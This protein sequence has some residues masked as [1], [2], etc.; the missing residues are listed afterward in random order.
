MQADLLLSCRG[1]EQRGVEGMG[2]VGEI[3]RRRERVRRS[4]VILAPAGQIPAQFGATH[5]RAL[6]REVPGTRD[7]GDERQRKE[8]DYGPEHGRR[9]RRAAQ[10]SGQQRHHAMPQLHDPSPQP[11]PEREPIE[12]RP[13]EDGADGGA[14]GGVGKL[15]DEW[16]RH[17]ARVGA[18]TDERGVGQRYSRTSLAHYALDA[19][20]NERRDV[21]EDDRAQRSSGRDEIPGF[22]YGM[23]PL[24]ELAYP[25]KIVE[26]LA[27]SE[28][29]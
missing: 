11:V 18:G 1:I 2:R 19:A 17:G 13:A 25:L 6:E 24:L 20:R 15:S 12:L 26:S 10:Q 4:P 7:D 21:G 8:R 27:V 23:E 14:D 28:H 9:M 5:T 29:G 16:E 22:P 3:P